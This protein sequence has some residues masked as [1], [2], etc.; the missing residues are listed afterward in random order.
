MVVKPTMEYP[1]YKVV[2]RLNDQDGDGALD[3]QEL[4]DFMVKLA[5]T[6]KPSSIDN[7]KKTI[8]DNL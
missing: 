5:G 2:F 8:Y 6:E 7:L 4:R 3:K 1:G